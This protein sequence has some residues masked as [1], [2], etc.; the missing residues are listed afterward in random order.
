MA[1]L[2]P[3]VISVL[4]LGPAQWDGQTSV[5]MDPQIA[6]RIQQLEQE[7]A[8]LR[9]ELAAIQDQRPVRLPGVAGGGIEQTSATLADPLTAPAVPPVTI[10]QVRAEAKK[11]AW[12][13]GDFTIT[14]YGILWAN[15]TYETQR[16]NTGDYVLYVYPPDPDDDPRFLVD[17]R[18]T[19]IGLDVAGPRIPL[20]C[21]AQSGGKVEIDFTRNLDTENRASILL[22][23]AYLEVKNEEFR[24]LFGQTWDVISPLYPGVLMY[25][26]GWGGGN[27][28]YRRAQ[29]RGERYLD[30]SDSLLLTLQACVARDVPS[31]SDTVSGVTYD[32]APWPV[33]ETR[34][35]TTWGPRGPGCLPWE[36]GFSGHIGQTNYDYASP[37]WPTRI[38]EDPLKTWSINADFRIPLTHWCGVQGEFFHGANLGTFFGGIIQS[39][40]FGTPANP[41]TGDVI[42]STGGW[43]DFWVDLTPRLHTHFGYSIDDPY[44]RDLTSGRTYNQFFFANVSYDVTKRFLVGFEV[45]D[46]KTNWIGSGEAKSLNMATVAKYGF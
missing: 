42:R 23:H 41:G 10:E 22:R 24:L 14:P 44:N 46:W 20:F 31:L 36:F 17:G 25:S 5:R 39:V 12:T 33:I 32:M 2:V 4:L 16:T 30:C 15:M 6:A 1:I 27:I 28:G 35:G 13:K 9:N 18:M 37:P 8:A 3:A 40:D 21:C 38:A 19:R 45:T 43:I 29:F 26:V 34:V 11:F 7:T